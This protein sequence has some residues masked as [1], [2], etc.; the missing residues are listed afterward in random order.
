MSYLNDRNSITLPDRGKL[1][2]GNGVDD[3]LPLDMEALE[4]RMRGTID[5]V[6]A[7]DRHQGVETTRGN[8]WA[9]IELIKRRG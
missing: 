3:F 7:A 1:H 5:V 6:L 4:V 8:M 9:G 2:E